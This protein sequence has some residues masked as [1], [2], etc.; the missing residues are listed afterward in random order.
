M[1]LLTSADFVPIVQGM[2]LEAVD[3]WL[4]WDEGPDEGVG[5][6]KP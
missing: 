2:D 4:E 6:P 1:R 3:A 5:F